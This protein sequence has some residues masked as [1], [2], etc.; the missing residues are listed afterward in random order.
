VLKFLHLFLGG[1]LVEMLLS[2][3][4]D[5]QLFPTFPSDKLGQMQNQVF[6]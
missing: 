6:M 4:N 1:F 5:N 3:V 2:A